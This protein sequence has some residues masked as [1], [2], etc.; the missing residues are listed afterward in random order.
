MCTDTLKISLCYGQLGNYLKNYDKALK[1]DRI[2]RVHNLIVYEKCQ[3]I[4]ET[5]QWKNH[6]PD[7]VTYP[8][9]FGN[10]TAWALAWMNQER[11][12]SMFL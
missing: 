9:A 6:Y 4:L 8:E 1:S 10:C 3:A 11:I 12:Y 2:S 5:A 7:F